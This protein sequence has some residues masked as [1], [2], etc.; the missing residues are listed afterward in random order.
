VTGIFIHTD[1]THHQFCLSFFLR[2]LCYESI[3]KKM[4]W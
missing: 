3:H 2:Y 4:P 1:V